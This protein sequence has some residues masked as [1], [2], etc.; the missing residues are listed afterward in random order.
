MA[1]RRRRPRPHGT[2]NDR[3]RRPI[4]KKSSD[5]L[6]VRHIL[7]SVLLDRRI[8]REI[9]TSSANIAPDRNDCSTPPDT[10]PAYFDT[11]NAKTR[12]NTRT[13]AP[14]SGFDGKK[15]STI[16]GQWCERGHGW[17]SAR[18]VFWGPASVIEVAKGVG[19]S[20]A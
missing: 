5:H 6:T 9:S 1:A 10:N 20:G 7:E 14:I 19:V 15:F 17:T 8:H 4:P 11:N 2:L 16:F 18:G 12:T 3:D 13:S